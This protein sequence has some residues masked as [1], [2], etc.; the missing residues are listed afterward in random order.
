M[1]R[2]AGLLL[3]R[4]M[5]GVVGGALVI[6]GAVMIVTPGPG[7]LIIATG[8]AVLA[9][10]FEAPRRWRDRTLAWLQRQKQKRAT[11]RT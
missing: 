8:L 11:P 7:V 6:I 9:F 5:I 2:L 10:E 4:L 1:I 3:W